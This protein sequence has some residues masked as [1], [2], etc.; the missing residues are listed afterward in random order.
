MDQEMSNSGLILGLLPAN[1]RRRYFVTTSLI[2][3]AQTK[4][5]PC[6][7]ASWS[8]SAVPQCYDAEFYLWPVNLLLN[9]CPVFQYIPWWLLWS[10][11][12]W[13]PKC[14]KFLCW[15]HRKFANKIVRLSESCSYLTCVTAADQH[16]FVNTIFYL[17]CY[18][19]F[20]NSEDLVK[21]TELRKLAWQ[22][23]THFCTE[24]MDLYDTSQVPNKAY[25]KSTGAHR[26]GQ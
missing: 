7:L 14:Q 23:Q 21:I 17:I 4:N 24:I 16:M 26:P 1:E 6:K 9:C 2:G 10:Q 3:W 19:H 12:R 18:H 20:H 5:Q 22:P 8:I 11:G 25:S 13:V 15:G